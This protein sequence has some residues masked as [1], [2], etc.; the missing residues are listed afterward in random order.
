MGQRRRICTAGIPQQRAPVARSCALHRATHRRRRCVRRSIDTDRPAMAEEGADTPAHRRVFLANSGG[1]LAAVC[2]S[3]T[4]GS[5]RSTPCAP[6]LV[7]DGRITQRRAT[8]VLPDS[9]RRSRAPTD[10]GRT[11]AAISSSLSHRSIRQRHRPPR[12]LLRLSS[13]RPVHRSPHRRP[14]R[15][16]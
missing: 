6:S 1:A 15:R 13:H 7:L 2:G 12:R 4:H 14:R 3:R 9:A 11:A 10:I 5:V 8:D 16:Q